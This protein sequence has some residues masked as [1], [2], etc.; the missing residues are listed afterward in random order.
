VA[1]LSS[2]KKYGCIICNPPYG[3]RLGEVREAEK[4]Y[5]LMG[6]VFGRLDTWSFYVLTSHEDFERLFGRKADRKRKLYNGRIKV[7][8]Y[9]FHGPRPPKRGEDNIIKNVGE[10]DIV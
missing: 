7:D 2:K 8:Y 6:E 4:L 3:E 5:R 10:E 9:Q 1:D